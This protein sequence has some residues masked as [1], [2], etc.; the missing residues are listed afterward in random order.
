MKSWGSEF[1]LG[2]KEGGEEGWSWVDMAISS[3]LGGFWLIVQAS[4]CSAIISGFRVHVLWS[5]ML[6]L[7]KF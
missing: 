7:S 1:L 2:N 4:I 3:K 6:C 5:G